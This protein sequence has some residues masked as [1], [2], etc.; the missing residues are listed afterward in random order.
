MNTLKRYCLSA[1]IAALSVVNAQAADIVDTAVGAGSFQT[2]VAAAKAAGL[3]DTLKS[4]GPLTVFAPT[5]DAFAK[6]PDGTVETLLKPENKAKL[7]AILT[8]HVVPGKV[9]AAD[10]VNVS[11]AKT[12]QGQQVDVKVDGSNVM[13]DNAN[14]VKT[15]IECDN[16]VIHVIDSVI[17]PADKSVVETAVAAG[18]FKTLVAAVK[19]AGLVETLSGDGPFTVF[20]PT[21]EAFAK[22]PEGT[23]E[24]LLKPENKQKLID[25]LTYHVVSGRVYSSDAVA[26]KTAKSLQGSTLTVKVSDSGAMINDAGLVKTDIDATNG[27]IHVIDSVLLPPAKGANAQQVIHGAIAQGS[28]LFNAGHHDA[29][30]NLYS[31]TMHQLMD[32]D[33]DP[34]LRHHLTSVMQT[35]NSQHCPTTRAWTLRHGMDQMYARLANK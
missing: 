21:D 18:S 23:V 9:M 14:V 4:D 5:D 8:Y 32:T 19:A 6:L 27:V 24:N 12:V 26:A 25:I 2:L 10:V 31:Q 11:G 29:C 33:L 35:A 30:A 20:A 22:L 3:V 7:A 17:L 15:D 1:A 28:Q 34:S 16:G 13:I